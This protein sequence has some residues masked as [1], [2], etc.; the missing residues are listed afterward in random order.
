MAEEEAYRWMQ[1]EEG[2]SMEQFR[3]RRVSGV[4]PTV[5]LCSGESLG[6]IFAPAAAAGVGI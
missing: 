1:V 6:R 5:D 2:G 3:A 4:L